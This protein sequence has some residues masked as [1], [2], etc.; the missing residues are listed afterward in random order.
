MDHET[1]TP[2]RAC[3]LTLKVEAD[4]PADMVCALRHLSNQIA[5]GEATTGTSGGVAASTIYEYVD[6]GTPSHDEYFV[7]LR[8][9]LA[10]RRDERLAVG[11]KS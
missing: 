4:S 7:Q 2:H 10:K 3:I 6:N 1:G 11:V 9:Y 5:S 8:A